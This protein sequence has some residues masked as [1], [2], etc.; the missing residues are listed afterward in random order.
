MKGSKNGKN[1]QKFE[2]MHDQ[3]EPL[4]FVFS[5][6]KIEKGGHM[7]EHSL[8]FVNFSFKWQVRSHSCKAFFFNINHQSSPSNTSPLQVFLLKSKFLWA[9]F[10]NYI[11]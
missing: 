10:H 7:I 11:D 1:Y 2:C 4:C 3:T 9:H 8:D 6:W 5:M